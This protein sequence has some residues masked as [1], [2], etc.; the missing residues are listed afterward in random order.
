L[1]KFRIVIKD[2]KDKII[3]LVNSVVTKNEIVKKFIT[4]NNFLLFIVPIFT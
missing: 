2:K 1:L 4:K 3:I